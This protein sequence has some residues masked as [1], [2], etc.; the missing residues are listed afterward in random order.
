MKGSYVIL[1]IHLLATLATRAHQKH[2]LT[3]FSGLRAR[4]RRWVNDEETLETSAVILL[5]IIERGRYC[6]KFLSMAVYQYPS[7]GRSKLMASKALSIWIFKMQDLCINLRISG[8]QGSL[9]LSTIFSE[10]FITSSSTPRLSQS[11]LWSPTASF[12]A[13]FAPRL[14][15]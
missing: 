6:Q 13:F 11:S 14:R 9:A 15:S 10:V 4:C 1:S 8:R 2:A 3:E 5:S 7:H 12:N